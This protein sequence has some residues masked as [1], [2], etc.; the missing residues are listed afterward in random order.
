[1]PHSYSL[2]NGTKIPFTPEEIDLI[3]RS[4]TAIT[5]DMN[6]QRV[7]SEIYAAK[8]VQHASENLQGSNEQMVGKMLNAAER[9]NASNDR[10]ATAMKWLTAA[11]VFVAFVQ[12]V[13]QIIA[14]LQTPTS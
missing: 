8:L 11:L 10:H 14:F 5:H 1:M 9:I 12:V 7:L 2:Q 13:M 6:Q 4:K 3:E